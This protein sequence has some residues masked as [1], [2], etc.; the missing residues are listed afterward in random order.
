LIIFLALAGLAGLKASLADLS[1]TI[2]VR[3]IRAS[4]SALISAFVKK[5][6]LFATQTLSG[7]TITRAAFRIA[8]VANIIS[9]ITILS[10]RTL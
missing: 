1:S 4:L 10:Y 2:R 8:V 6:S 9:Y 7:G 5:I 3:L